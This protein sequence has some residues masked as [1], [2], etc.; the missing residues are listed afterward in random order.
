MTVDD[1]EWQGDWWGRQVLPLTCLVAKCAA[2]AACAA[3]PLPLEDG[4]WLRTPAELSP[5]L[6]Q[7][8]HA[9]FCHWLLS[10]PLRAV[11]LQI[12]EIRQWERLLVA[13]RQVCREGRVAGERKADRQT[14]RGWGGGDGELHG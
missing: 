7:P 9:H 11:P 2:L 1:S 10:V 12:L 8:S 6:H 4:A 3:S 13:S 14:G 5:L